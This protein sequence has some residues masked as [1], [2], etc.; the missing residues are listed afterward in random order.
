[1]RSRRSSRLVL[2]AIF[3][4]TLTS[5]AAEPLDVL[6]ATSK[7][8]TVDLATLKQGEVV[9]NRGPL[10]TFSH[11]VYVESSYFI[12]APTPM[13][14]EKLLHWNPMKHGELEVQMLR[15]FAWPAPPAVFDSLALSSSRAE[16]KWL[17]DRTWQIAPKHPGELHL[18]ANEPKQFRDAVR[19]LGNAPAAPQREGKA[20][21][22]WRRI[23]R[24]RNDAVAAGGLAA[25]PPYTANDEH[26]SQAMEFRNLMRIAPAIAARFAPLLSKAPFTGATN[27]PDELVP[28]WEAA[29]VRGHTSLHGG[30]LSARKSAAS[31]Q[32]ADCTYFASDTYF[33]SVNLYELWPVENGTLVWQIDFVS[34]PF[35]GFIGNVDRIFAGKAMIKD[36]VQTAKLFRADAEQH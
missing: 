4:A 20:S 30:F 35:R 9:S 22:F 34:A 12:H 33:F 3:V 21:E 36:D 15:E 31:W 8:P 1:M 17:I 28:Y 32:I 13:V 25:L 18:T 11:G 26:V 5:R 2:V 7:L 14:G 6:H 23:L 24:A 19:S 16:D 10:G 27:P 29:L